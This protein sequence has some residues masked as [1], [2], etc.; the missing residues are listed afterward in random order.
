MDEKRCEQCE[1]YRSAWTEYF[2]DVVITRPMAGILRRSPKKHE[3]TCKSP[4]Q[5]FGN[6]QVYYHR[7]S[8]LFFDTLLGRCGKRGRWFKK[9]NTY[10]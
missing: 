2:P 5:R 4:K 6:L 9:R 8:W 3:A 7:L 10:S 1:N